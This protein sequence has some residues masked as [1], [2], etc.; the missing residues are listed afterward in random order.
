MALFRDSNTS[1]IT[2]TGATLFDLVTKDKMQSLQDFIKT[3][4]QYPRVVIQA[5]D[6]PDH[7]AVAS[8]FALGHLLQLSGIKTLLL[9]NGM[10]DRISLQ[11]MIETLAIPIRHWQESDLNDN[12]IIITVDGCIGEKNVT[13]LPGSE[14]AVIDHHLVTP[15]PGLWFTDVR[16]EY[17]STATIIFEYY[18]ALN[19]SI[20]TDVATALQIGQAIDTANLTR[21]FV[22]ADID[23]FSHL[24]NIADQEL[25]S[26]ISRNS[27]QQDE[28][29]Y[30]QKLLEDV[31]IMDG[32]AFAF[33]VEG[34]PKNMLGILGDFLL[35]LNEV[36]VVIVAAN[37]PDNILLSLRSECSQT[38]A[39]ILVQS[40][41]Q[42]NDIGFGGG[43]SHMAGGII[44]REQFEHQFSIADLSQLFLDCRQ[45]MR[46]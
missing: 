33:L 8:A 14:I 20:P 39:A 32:M 11:N 2:C 34:C 24:H 22:Q 26:R 42:D 5:H 44:K 38:N 28:L 3:L 30:Y 13:D 18:Q 19:T 9:Y 27:I 7:D 16:Q 21:G 40:V 37:T 1:G 17:G 23:A 36:D 6:F 31:Q 43:H 25:V 15:P 29:L 46:N 41:V 4:T 10:I 45:E 35:A 12:D